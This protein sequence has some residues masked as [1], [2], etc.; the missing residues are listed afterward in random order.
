MHRSSRSIII[1][2]VSYNIA[3]YIPDMYFGTDHESI[4][5]APEVSVCNEMVAQSFI[6]Y[7]R[8]I[9]GKSGAYIPRYVWGIGEHQ[10][11]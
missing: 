7:I 11:V 10:V 4:G 5:G 1:G 9:F 2:A 8:R 3:G 6:D